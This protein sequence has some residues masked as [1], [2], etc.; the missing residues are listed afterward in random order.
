MRDNSIGWAMVAVAV[1][2]MALFAFM[3]RYEP[4]PPVGGVLFVWDRL[5]H[6]ACAAVPD[7][8]SAWDVR[9]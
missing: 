5:E 3:S 1:I 8:N 6:R 4:L 9:C 2:A 7:S